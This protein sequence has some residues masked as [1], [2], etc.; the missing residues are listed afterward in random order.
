M[1]RTTQL[2]RRVAALLDPAIRR[3]RAG[4]GF[5]GCAAVAAGMVLALASLQT[6]LLAQGRLTGVVRDAS[7]GVIPRARLD[8]K[9]ADESIQEVVYSS[10][11]GEFAIPSV[12]DGTYTLTVA[13]PGFALLTLTGLKYEAASTKPLELWLNVGMLKERLQ[14]TSE[15]GVRA[16]APQ[17]TEAP[18]RIR[19]GGNVQAAK[20]VSQARPAYPVTAKTDGV[21]GTVLLRAVIGLDGTVVNLE[22]VNRTVDARLVEAARDAV[23]QW[24]YSPTLLNGNPVEVITI[25][26]V[27]FTL[28]R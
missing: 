8:L 15:S 24:R 18:R 12:P 9:S 26:E 13:S 20:L 2:Q 27:N 4:R 6:P 28:L 3:Q 1:T 25:V 11:A 10:A 7:S 17:A 21:E 16:A 5:V 14:V 22:Q 19:V 23:K